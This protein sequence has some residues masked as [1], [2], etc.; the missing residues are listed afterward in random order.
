MYK[1]TA[2]C[3]KADR[4]S[5]GDHMPEIEKEKEIEIEKKNVK[6][7]AGHII[8]EKTDEKEKR[9][10][11][12]VLD[13]DEHMSEKQKLSLMNKQQKREYILELA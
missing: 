7:I 2:V 1:V 13:V 10:P 3:G 5:I 11:E 9:E 12:S 6:S 4:S 8:D